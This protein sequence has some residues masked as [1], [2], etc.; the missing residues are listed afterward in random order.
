MRPPGPSGFSLPKYARAIAYFNSYLILRPT[1]MMGF[2][3]TQQLFYALGRP[4][5]L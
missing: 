3:S 5:H 2:M 1:A 4:K